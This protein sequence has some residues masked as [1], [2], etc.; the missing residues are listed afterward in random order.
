MAGILAL[1][2]NAQPAAGTTATQPVAPPL[3][4]ADIE[5]LVEQLTPAVTKFREQSSPLKVACEVGVT[6]NLGGSLGTRL[7]SVG[8]G[9]RVITHWN[10][11]YSLVN[12]ST[13][14]QVVQ[15]SGVFPYNHLRQTL[16]QINGGATIYAAD[17]LG[18]FAVMTRN[19]PG[20]WAYS[21]GSGFGLAL[22]KALVKVTP[23]GNVSAVTSSTGPTFSGISQFTVAASSTGT[24][25]V[26]FWTIEKLALDRQSLLGVLPAQNNSTYATITRQVVNSAIGASGTQVPPFNTVGAV[27]GTLTVTAVTTVNST[28]DFWSVPGDPGLY[29]E[30]VQNSYQVQQQQ[31]I[32]VPVTGPAALTYNV[33][34]NQ[35]LVAAHLWGFD[36]NGALIPADSGG[37][38]LL[39]I[40]YNAQA[41]QPIQHFADR[42]RAAQFLDYGDDRQFVGGYRFWDGEDTTELVQVADQAGWID[43]Y[44]AATPQIIG[45]MAAAGLVVPLTY[46]ITRESVVAGAV[47]VVGG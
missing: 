11:V 18:T 3:T 32:A 37:I 24:L 19:K 43:T 1:Q 5:Q 14:A 28:Y 15:V 40:V 4:S 34:Q 10:V 33:P 26:D 45:D 6:M 23:G 31:S 25:T 44:A 7:P 20:S 12:S 41:I 22:S 36:N 2:S 17:G 16:I 8:L 13:A 42:E 9:V 38:T 46:S 29:Q 47:Q 39:R 21:T 35:F 30:M 27:P